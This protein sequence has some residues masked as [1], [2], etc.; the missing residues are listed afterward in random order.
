MMEPDEWK[1]RLDDVQELKY[2]LTKAEERPLL[3]PWAFWVWGGLIVL[4]TALNVVVSGQA[5]W[6]MGQSFVRLWLPLFVV[7]AAVESLAFLSQLRQ[8]QTPWASASFLRALGG[9]VGF[10]FAGTL[11]F[12]A[13]L[14]P[15]NP[16]PAIF[17]LFL[18]MSFFWV[19]SVSFTRLYFLAL[20]AAL[21]GLT[22][23]LG[24]WRSLAAYVASGLLCA[25][26]FVV[27]GFLSRT[28]GSGG[29]G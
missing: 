25:G 9:L 1:K 12:L 21:A 3:K 29:R 17:L 24:D 11:L 19:A 6:T 13:V 2:L 26:V 28:P 10:W 23:Y 22:F 7:G 16:L 5:R 4:G 20:F 18:S 27:G 8:D 15:E 14:R